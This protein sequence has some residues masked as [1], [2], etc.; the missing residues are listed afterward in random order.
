MASSL[1]R[2]RQNIEYWLG[3]IT[4]TL[5]NTRTHPKFRTY[6]PTKGT[7]GNED[8]AARL[9]TVAWLGSVEDDEATADDFRTAIHRYEIDVLY[10]EA[11]GLHGDFQDLVTLDRHDLI[12]QLRR[13]VTWD[14]YN[15]SNTTTNIGLEDR[16]REGDE[17]IEVAPQVFALR[18]VWLHRVKEDE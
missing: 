17:L 13:T 5:S 15:A 4:P 8:G 12:K 3:Q 9:F 11:V 6:E 7:P 1:Y 2:V 16:V 10:P 14:G 18:M